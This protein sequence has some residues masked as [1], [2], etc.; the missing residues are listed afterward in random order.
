MDLRAIFAHAMLS[1]HPP[2]L[3]GRLL[4]DTTRAGEVVPLD[5]AT[6]GDVAASKDDRPA[7]V[8][9]SEGEATDGNI[10]LQHWDLSR[11]GTVGVPVLW[12]HSPDVLLGRW[13]DAKVMPLEKTSLVARAFFDPEDPVAQNRRRQVKQGLLSAVSVGWRPGRMIRRGELDPSDPL[14]KPAEEGD[15][16]TAGEGYVMGTPEEPNGLIEGSLT[17]TPSDPRAVVT[18]RLHRI[19]GRDVAAFS[20]GEGLKLDA[21]LPLIAADPKVRAWLDQRLTRIVR[22]ELAKGSP[23]PTSK[24]SEHLLGRMFSGG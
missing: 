23:S 21:L 18:E 3:I 16:G 8:L 10:I 17:P 11:I 20:K 7:F 1:G 22:E 5:P 4:A 13:E 6:G 14:Y 15:C 12:N 2:A 9:S 19:A 24:P